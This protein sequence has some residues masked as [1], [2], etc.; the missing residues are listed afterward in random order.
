[1]ARTCQY[2]AGDP[3]DGGDP[4]AKKCGA[5]TAGPAGSPW[6]SYHRQI[7]FRRFSDPGPEP[8]VPATPE[9]PAMP[10]DMDEVA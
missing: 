6:C 8:E 5:P 9:T 4:D 7:V 1:M 3:L 10:E 2:I